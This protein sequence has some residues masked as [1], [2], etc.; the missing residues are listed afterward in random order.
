MG[1]RL[2]DV[3]R[4]G[5]VQVTGGA[6]LGAGFFIAPGIVLPC[7]HVAGREGDLT[8]RWER[9]GRP[10]QQ[11]RAER[12]AVLADM[13]DPIPALE[14]SYPDIAVLQVAELS[15]HPCVG[16]DPSWPAQGDHFLGFG[17]PREGGAPRLTPAGL[18]Y[19][20]TKGTMPLGY[21]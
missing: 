18:T 2:G 5:T 21:L 10:P 8:A 4:D 7:P 19:R 12:L 1:D 3:L 15:E 16:I 20:G 6:I 11:A 17:Y 9:D 13:G 14:A